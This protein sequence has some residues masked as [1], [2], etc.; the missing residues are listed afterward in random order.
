MISHSSPLKWGFSW[1]AVDLDET[2]P[3]PAARFVHLMRKLSAAL[4]HGGLS[5]GGNVWPWRMAM[6]G[7]G[8]VAG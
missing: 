1:L 7:L 5:H 2:L 6:Q 8:G 4:H 3:S